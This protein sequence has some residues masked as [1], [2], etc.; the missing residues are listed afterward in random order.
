[1]LSSQHTA[2]KK[3]NCGSPEG[4]AA[5]EMWSTE[6]SPGIL[7]EGDLCSAI[8]GPAEDLG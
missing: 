2:L 4:V 6:N 5:G 8:L 3:V 1:M 7:W